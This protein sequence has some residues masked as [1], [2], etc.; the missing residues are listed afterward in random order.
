MTSSTRDV[1]KP[2]GP[3]LA[4]ILAA[5]VGS[6]FLGLFTTL[7]EANAS[8]SKAIVLNS[9]VGAL[10]GKTT[11]AVVAWLVAWA[12]AYFAM[13]GKT[14]SAQPIVNATFVL[15]A[16]GLLLTFPLFFDLFAP[17]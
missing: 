10:S 16:L 3:A 1:A 13:R 11:Y 8:F 15:I 2:N 17:K 4:A 12:I 6:F 5:G 14:Y 9:G 7:A